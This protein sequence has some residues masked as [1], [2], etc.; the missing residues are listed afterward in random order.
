MKIRNI[1]LSLIFLVVSMVDSSVICRQYYDLELKSNFSLKRDDLPQEFGDG[2]FETVNE[3]IGKTHDL[4]CEWAIYFDYISGEIL[5][6]GKGENDNVGITFRECEFEDHHV[7]SIH[8]HPK[9]ILSAPSYKNFRIFERNFEDY[10]L[11]AGFECF[12]I[13][14]AKGLHK[15]LIEEVN[16]TSEVLALTSFVN[17]AVRYRNEDIINRMHDIVYGNEL[18]KYINDKNIIDI[19][20]LKKEYASMDNNLKTAEFECLKR[21]SGPD[22]IRLAREFEKCP[23]T[24]TAKEILYNY[25]QSIGVDVDYDEIFAD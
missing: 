12:W 15:N 6:C 13:L 1:F 10:E 16:N 17:C 3:F 8:N 4:D 14:K 21:I 24:P 18:L 25:Y 2:A 23:F 22:A 19:Q 11:I 9:D 7:A 5:K 20:L